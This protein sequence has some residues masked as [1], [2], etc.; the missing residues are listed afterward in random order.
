[1]V[2]TLL[3]L[4]LFFAVF[5]TSVCHACLRHHSPWSR[6]GCW[7][8]P[9]RA[10]RCGLWTC[11]HS[12]QSAVS[13]WERKLWIIVFRDLAKFLFPL[14]RKSGPKKGEFQNDCQQILESEI[15]KYILEKRKRG[16][17]K[18]KYPFV[19]FHKVE[20]NRDQASSPEV[21]VCKEGGE[22]SARF[23]C[24]LCLFLLRG[25]H[26]LFCYKKTKTRS[27]YLCWAEHHYDVPCLLVPLAGLVNHFERKEWTLWRK[28]NPGK[29]TWAQVLRLL[30]TN[31]S[32]CS[33]K[34]DH[35]VRLSVLKGKGRI[36]ARY[37]GEG[38]HRDQPGLVVLQDRPVEPNCTLAS[39]DD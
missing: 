12:A 38:G 19:E 11:S 31:N 5:L 36:P 37:V 9:W 3:H 18:A 25:A 4:H 1:M 17:L 10:R 28:R 7:R 6:F 34:L 22:S 32:D 16:R 35:N 24:W 2:P 20:Y 26:N 29:L 39:F 14:K 33:T 30:Q 15:F 21:D 23:C 8:A 27:D 13:F